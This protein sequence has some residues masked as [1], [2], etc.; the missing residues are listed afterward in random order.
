MPLITYIPKRFQRAS[1]EIIE[2]SIDICEDYAANG[3]ELTLR[4]LYYRHVAAGFLPNSDKSYKRL[5]TI[6]N[7]ARLAG[8]IDWNL[9]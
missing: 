9:L 8:M 5:G 6:I 7:D 1:Q 4:Q 2:R 3:Y